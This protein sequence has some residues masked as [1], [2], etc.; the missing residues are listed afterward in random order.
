MVMPGKSE[1]NHSFCGNRQILHGVQEL[2]GCID[3]AKRSCG[4]AEGHPHSKAGEQHDVNAGTHD[5]KI[6]IHL[7]AT[8][9]PFI[10]LII[11]SK[12]GV[13]SLN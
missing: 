13:T 8:S 9:T 1:S 10:T 7:L 3:T 4:S 11:R 5:G 2:L 6:R 12:G